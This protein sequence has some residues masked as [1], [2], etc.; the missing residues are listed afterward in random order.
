MR[1]P[2]DAGLT[3]ATN[4]EDATGRAPETNDDWGF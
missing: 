2:F 4:I 3:A 1:R